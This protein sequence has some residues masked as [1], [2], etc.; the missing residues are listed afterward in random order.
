MPVPDPISPVHA[1]VGA[2]LRRLRVGQSLT[3]EQLA[4]LVG[5]HRTYLNQV[6]GGTRN[7]SLGVLA[8]FAY[9]LGESL[10]RVVG[11]ADRLN[12]VGDDVDPRPTAEQ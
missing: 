11:V 7:V 3:S 12:L 8:K 2:E 10:S 1:A 4:G 5:V 6:E 9:V